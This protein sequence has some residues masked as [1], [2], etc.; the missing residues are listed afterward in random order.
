MILDQIVATTWKLLEER[1]IRK[2][3]VQIEQVLSQQ[4]SPTDLAKAL[5]GS[6]IKLLAEVKRASPSRGVFCPDL[7]PGALARDYTRGGASAISVLTEPEYFKGSLADLEKVRA[8][9][10]LPILCKDFIVDSY[11]IHEARACGADSVLLIVAILS[12][13]KMRELLGII[14]SLAMTALVEIHNREE[15]ERALALNP[16]IIGINNRNLADFSVDL[17]T[18]LQLRPFIPRDKVVVSESGISKRADVLNLEDAGVD[19]ILV[20]ESLVSSSDPAGK[21]KELLGWPK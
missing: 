15:L 1:K 12:Q 4:S 5:K 3:L 9:V 7:D 8:E 2:P 13:V 20:G 14:H 11:Q 6:S 18:T 17:R 21:I 19:A 16:S 10:A